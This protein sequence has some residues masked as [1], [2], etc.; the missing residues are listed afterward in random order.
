MNQL[1]TL[2]LL[3]ALL[4]SCSGQ[5]LSPSSPGL[6]SHRISGT[7]YGSDGRPASRAIVIITKPPQVDEMAVIR[8]DSLG[9]FVL[10]TSEAHVSLA[11]ATAR[12]WAFVPDVRPGGEEMR[13]QLSNQC[14]VF[15][16]KVEL[17]DPSPVT[18]DTLRIGG[19]DAQVRGLFGVEVALDF[20]FEACLPPGEYYISLPANFAERI[21]LTMVP[22]I[23]GLKVRA[24]TQKY[25]TA[26]PNSPLDIVAK[27]QATIV[28][29]LP[30]IVRILGLGESNHGTAEYTDERVELSLAL[31]R[32]RGF[33]LIMLEAGYGEVLPVDDY[34]KGA[35]IDIVDVIEDLGVWMWRTQSF[36]AALEK[37]RAYNLTVPASDQIG[38]MGID[39]QRTK[40]AVTE[41]I[42]H[43]N[44]LAAS[45]L[46]ILKQ[47]GEDRGRKWLSFASDVKANTR[48]KLE[49]LAAARDHNGPGSPAN[50]TALAA[51]SILLRLDLLEQHGFWNLERARDKGLAQMAQEALSL[52]P[53]LR[54]T[55]WAHLG[56]VSREFVVGAATMGQH[57]ATW[58]GDG[59]QVWALLG[60]EVLSELAPPN[61]RARLSITF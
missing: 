56:H 18:F 11:A 24:V 22:P 6:H 17:D 51:R 42:R 58:L 31:A 13:V 46:N 21:I 9:R 20:S 5:Q 47:L 43:K 59:Y 8:A 25:A 16:G 60:V 54:A 10:E 29:G 12:E 38:I 28:D 30:D 4:C 53:R 32:E 35:H 61:T 26:P 52:D 33:S 37:L 40:G 27:T 1:K 23:N 19:F 2:I 14:A 41:L 57:L 7:V 48:Q 36:L 39:I 44:F 15:R 49:L 45:D 50:R 34:I 3:N 55:L